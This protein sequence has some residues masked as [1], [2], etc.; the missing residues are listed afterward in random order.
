MPTL[1]STRFDADGNLH[2]PAYTLSQSQL[3]S[4]EFRQAFA[5]HLNNAQSW[6][7]LATPVNAPKD[8][9]DRYDAETDRLIFG[10]SA[11][12][13]EEN[14]PVDIVDTKMAGVHFGIITSKNGVDPR[15]EHRVLINLHGGGFTMGRGLVA[16]KGESIP[17]ASVGRIKVVTVDYRMVPYASFSSRERRC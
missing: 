16:G 10:P 12:W 8:D 4:N 9:W 7:L 15:T 11:A 3:V 14:Y 2:I 6:L 17:V 1:E 5:Q 13:A